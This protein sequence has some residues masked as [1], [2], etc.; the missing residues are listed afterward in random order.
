MGVKSYL[1]APFETGQ[2]NDIKPWLIP[3]DAFFSLEDAYVWRGRVR[4]RY[5]ASLIGD[6]DLDSRLRIAVDFTNGSGN[7]S[8]TVPGTVFKVGQMFSIDDEIYTVA[9]SGAATMLDTGSTTTK[10]YNTATGAYAFV[11]ATANTT[12]YFY[13]AEPVMGLS[14]RETTSVNFETT[15]AFDTQFAYIRQSGAWERLGSAIWTG[16]NS[17][18]FWSIN[19]RGAS[20]DL[21]YFYVTNFVSAD[22]I[23]YIPLGSSTWTNFRPQLNTGGTRFLETCRLILNFKNRL[24]CFNTV[25]STSGVPASYDNRC[26]FSQNGDPTDTTNGWL[27]DTPGRGGY[28]DCPTKEQIITAEFIKDQLI[29]YF[30]RSTWE[31]AYTGDYTLPFRWKQ[32]NTELGAESTFSVIPFDQ[33]VLAV[34]NVGIVTCNGVNVSRIDEKIPDAVFE[35]HNTDEGPARVYGIRDYFN[36]MVLWTFPAAVNSP[37]YPTRILAYNYMNNTFAFFNDSFTC[38]GYFQKDSTLTWADLGSIYGTWDNWNDPWGGAPSQSQFPFIAAGNQQGFV[39]ILNSGKSANA[40]SLY[41]TDM[42]SGTQNITV[43]DHNLQDG[44]YLLFEDIQGGITVDG[45]SINGQIF[46]VLRVNS[47]TL[48]LF[49]FAFSGTYTGAGKLTRVSNINILTKQFN[50][51]TP[52]GQQFRFPYIDIL[53][54]RTEAGEVSLNYY[55]NTTSLS[56]QDNASPGV[57]LGDNTLYT[58]PEDNQLGQNDQDLIWHRFFTQTQGQFLQLQFTMDDEQMRDKEIALSNFELQGMMIY[59]TPAGRLIG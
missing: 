9:T 46:Q 53:L 58:R 24:L 22:N 25:E 55:M 13:P 39:H 12:V 34:G 30:E 19:A 20:P 56:V 38:F 51:G 18:F 6:T 5:G 2:E 4:K 47:T 43:I 37:T 40:Q 50:P 10:T 57:I 41:I 33:G 7:A 52:V 54:S 26:R 11:G 8:G 17:D 27:D 31:L 32:I 29:V 23:K 49:E 48:T 21:T 36:Q 59:A 15:I 35:I 44:D 1:I 42:D 28:I 16:T 3:E 45:V 14:L